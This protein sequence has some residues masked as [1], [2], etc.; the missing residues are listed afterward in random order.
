MTWHSLALTPPAPSSFGSHMPLLIVSFY[1]FLS[2]R[3][4]GG[5]G[6]GL[7][8]YV[9]QV[10]WFVRCAMTH[11]YCRQLPKYTQLN[12]SF[13]HW[14]SLISLLSCL[15]QWY[16]AAPCLILLSQFERWSLSVCSCPLFTGLHFIC[17]KNH[18]LSVS[19]S[20][21]LSWSVRHST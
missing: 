19:L 7:G 2:F 13:L 8:F 18:G 11:H 1:C 10:R 15:L 9:P 6:V 4:G 17:D 12:H 14:L 3:N 16:P 20:S 5:G 21:S